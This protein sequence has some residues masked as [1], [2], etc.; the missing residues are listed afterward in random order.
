MRNAVDDKIYTVEE[1]IQF[2]WKSE[3]RH[4]FINGQLFE[5]PGEKDINNQMAGMVYI[6][7]INFLKGKGYQFY[8]HDIKVAIPGGKKFYYPDVFVT[9]EERNQSNQYIKNE[10]EIIVEVVSETTQVTDYVDKYIDFTKIPS[11]AYYIIVEPETILITVYERDET[12][13][14]FARKYTNLNVVVKLEKF[15]I[16]FLVKDIYQG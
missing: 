1:Y 8:S 13:N 10:P 9:K 5:M 14:W 6:L 4:E 15:Q 12:L 2:E 11:L 3:R 16:E 7:L